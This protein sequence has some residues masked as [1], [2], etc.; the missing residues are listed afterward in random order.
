MNLTEFLD[1]NKYI[2]AGAVVVII[3]I[4]IY[5]VY[6]K[7]EHFTDVSLEKSKVVI[8]KPEDLQ[9]HVIPQAVIV[10]AKDVKPEALANV[11]QVVVSRNQVVDHIAPSKVIMPI[12]SEGADISHKVLVH[13][14]EVKPDVAIEKVVAPLKDVKPEALPNVK[15]AVVAPSD[16]KDGLVPSHSVVAHPAPVAVI[17]KPED[18]KPS[19]DNLAIVKPSEVKPG[20]NPTSLVVEPS[21]AKVAT[22]II[23]PA[24]DEKSEIANKVIA[25][26][27]DVKPAAKPVHVVVKVSD[28]KP[29]VDIKHV[30]V[31]PHEATKP[32]HV[33]IHHPAIIAPH[34]IMV[35]PEQVVKPLPSHH[36]IVK[37]DEAKPDVPIHAVVAK[38]SDVK[39]NV[40]AQHVLIPLSKDTGRVPAHSVVVP[41]SDLKH[42]TKITHVVI[43]PHQ[44]KDN[45]VPHRV[46]VAPHEVP[47]HVIPC[48]SVVTLHEHPDALRIHSQNDLAK[49]ELGPRP[50]GSLY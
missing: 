44:M 12:S 39:P 8:S 45:V 49:H 35:K 28:V 32:T 5:S 26:V 46:I 42:D 17:A 18:A 7:K 20:V 36:V 11:Q 16:V 22:H 27:G 3:A 13:P 25:K 23:A 9:S 1:K 33:V 29:N 48:H 6:S 34:T 47:A 38:P 40:V 14:S 19:P 15:H 24:V 2:V 31:M 37:K 30:V 43:L 21:D 50:V 4:I 10:D 41:P